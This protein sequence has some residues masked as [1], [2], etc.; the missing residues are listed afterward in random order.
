[1]PT[2][3]PAASTGHCRVW[4]QRV[5]IGVGIG[6]LIA[7]AVYL[8]FLPSLKSGSSTSIVTPLN[9]KNQQQ[10]KRRR[11]VSVAI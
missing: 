4:T 1:M 8:V 7:G 3:K 2:P 5:F 9:A 6:I 11:K 10:M